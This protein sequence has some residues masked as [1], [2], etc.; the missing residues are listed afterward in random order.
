MGSEFYNLR[1]RRIVATMMLIAA[2]HAQLSVEAVQAKLKQMGLPT[3]VD[4]KVEQP[5]L[6]VPG[7]VLVAPDGTEI[8]TYIYQDA[9]ARERDSAAID[10]KTAAPANMKPHW[11]MPVSV[12]AEDNALLIVLARSPYTHQQIAGAF[13]APVQGIAVEGPV[14]EAVQRFHAALQE[15][16]VKKIEALVS[17]DLV[18]FENGERNNGWA[19]FRDNHLIPEMK[20][21]APKTR[22]E[23]VKVKESGTMAWAYTHATFT[24]Q[25]GTALTLWSNFVLEKRGNEW[26][27]VML[28]WSIGR[29]K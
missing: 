22:W 8:Q 21:P 15:R 29:T 7:R 9:A 10:P 28:D 13:A 17:A 4:V 1:M 11:L 19:D 5:Y 3:K 23:L 25:K 26:K 24:S 27:I 12:V 18:V 14:A 20:E 6:H 16:D 2:A